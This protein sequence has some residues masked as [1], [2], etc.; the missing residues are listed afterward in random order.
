MPTLN[1]MFPKMNEVYVF[2]N[3]MKNFMNVFKSMLGVDARTSTNACLS[4]LRHLLEDDSKRR[5]TAEADPQP[6]N[7]FDRT[8]FGD[9]PPASASV[10]LISQRKPM[11]TDLPQFMPTSQAP[12]VS[13]SRQEHKGD[14]VWG[15]VDGDT[16][17]VQP[18]SLHEHVMIARG[19]RGSGLPPGSRKAAHASAT[20]TQTNGGIGWTV[21]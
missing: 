2:V 18:T 7:P 3:E 8:I 1:G 13:S 10:P 12:A 17:P 11:P 6:A 5:Q 4:A 19:A 9:A 21:L 20:I 16:V 15:V 14:E